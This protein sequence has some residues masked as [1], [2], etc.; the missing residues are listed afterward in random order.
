M[1]SELLSERKKPPNI[2]APLQVY[3]LFPP[4]NY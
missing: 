2:D 1:Y 3:Q 4:K